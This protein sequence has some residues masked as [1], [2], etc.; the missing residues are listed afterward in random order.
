MIQAVVEVEA[1]SAMVACQRVADALD[2]E[3]YP[4]AEVQ[5]YE[6]R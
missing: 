5:C 2:Q 3:G 4:E 1:P 6:Q